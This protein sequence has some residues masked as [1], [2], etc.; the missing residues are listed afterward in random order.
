MKKVVFV[1][2]DGLGDRPLAEFNHQ[3]P[4]EAAETPNLDKLAAGGISGAMDTVDV[5]VRPGSDTAHLALFGYDPAVYYTGRGP[6]EVAG[7][8]MEVLPGDICFRANMGTVGKD[9]VVKDRRAGRIDDTGELVDLL[10]NSEIDGI[11]F[12][13]KKGVGHRVGLIM[14]GRGLSANIT[15]CDP[16]AEGVKVHQ[17]EAKDG[18]PEAVFTAKTL[19]KFLEM[20]HC[21]L[22]GLATNKEREKRG[23]LAANYVLVRGA[24]TLPQITPFFDKYHLKAV[25]I[26]GGGLYKGIAKLIGMDAPEI[27]GAT[28]KFDSDLDKKI[29]AV[30]KL[31]SRYDFF[32]VHIKA[33]DSYGEDGNCQGK[34]EFIEKIDRSLAPL[35]HLKDTLVVVTADH[36]TPCRLKAHSADDVPVVIYG[37]EIRDDDVEHFNE[38][39][40][41]KGRLGHIKGT[42]LM[43]IIID[44]MG[45]AELFGA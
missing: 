22:S 1:V 35:F 9:L 29:T 45:M 32:F 37:Q 33:A 38:R 11:S 18:T 27:K 28:G 2:I 41:A 10:N 19:N 23:E 4:L 25:C 30:L 14:R 15:D 40:C 3:T 39:E 36:S 20:A 26:A 17:A 13:L 6:F 43:P 24:G 5:G 44:M 16:H 31:Y 21:K 42:N 12:L 7:L 8:G 34:K